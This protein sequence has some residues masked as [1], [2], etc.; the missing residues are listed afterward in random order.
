[1]ICENCLKFGLSAV[2]G[3]TY[4]APHICQRQLLGAEEAWYGTL[5]L[6]RRALARRDLRPRLTHACQ[7]YTDLVLIAARHAIGE[8]VYVVA[9]L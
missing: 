3:A 5:Q 7:S 1:M 2:A 4:T 8:D 9:A 6:E